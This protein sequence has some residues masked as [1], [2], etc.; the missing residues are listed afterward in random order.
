M[1]RP[2]ER[3]ALLE[4]AGAASGLTLLGYVLLVLVFCL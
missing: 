3:R 1:S 4:D 2:C